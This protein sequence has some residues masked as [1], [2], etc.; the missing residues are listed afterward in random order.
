[1][2]KNVE[3]FAALGL[4]QAARQRILWDNAAEIIG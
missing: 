4:S 2:R 1:M 3:A